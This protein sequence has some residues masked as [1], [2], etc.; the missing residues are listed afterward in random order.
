M[1]QFWDL[2][3][4]TDAWEEGVRPNPFNL[5]STDVHQAPPGPPALGTSYSMMG[6]YLGVSEN[7]PA[8]VMPE[9]L[10]ALRLEMGIIAAPEP[11]TMYSDAMTV[12][13]FGVGAIS[14]DR[15]Q[16]MAGGA[17]PGGSTMVMASAG[18]FTAALMVAKTALRFGGGGSA[19]GLARNIFMGVAADSVLNWI[20]DLPFIDL[21]FYSEHEE[22]IKGIARHVSQAIASGE[23]RA[24]GKQH[25]TDGGDSIPPNYLVIEGMA[26]PNTPMKMYLTYNVYGSGYI[27]AVKEKRDTQWFRGRKGATARKRH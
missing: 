26:D 14:P 22:D 12:T 11:I 27:K 7:T 2:G 24:P 21:P 5:A 1:V 9:D 6:A 18:V 25:Y 20:D 13:A 23:I 15:L 10:N 4:A 3:Q 8:D 17:T 19:T 16:A